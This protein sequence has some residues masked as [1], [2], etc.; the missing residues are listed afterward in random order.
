MLEIGDF[1]RVDGRDFGIGKL[2]SFHDDTARVSWFHSPALPIV[3]EL[4]VPARSVQRVELDTQHRVYHH[5]LDTGTWRVGRIEDCGRIDGHHFGSDGDLYFVAFPNGDT[6]RVPIAQLETRWDRPLDAP[7]SIL[8]TRT[9]ITPFWHEGRAR[10]M[11]SVMTQRAACG[12]LTGLFSASVDLLEHQVRVVRTVLNDPIPR[13]L[14]ADEVGLGKTIEAIAILRQLVLERP[15]DHATLIVA[16]PH[17]HE[18]WA[19]EL[20]WRFRLGPLLGESIRIIDLSEI[21][22]EEP[23]RLL[24]VDEAHH[25]AGYAH[26]ASEEKRD[27]YRKLSRLAHKSPRLLLLSATPVLHNEDGFLAMLHLLDPVAYPL[28]DR[29]SFR[30]RVLQRQQIADWLSDLQDDASPLFMEDALDGLAEHFSGDARLME[31]V[32]F[33]R[34]FVDE[35]EDDEARQEML[36][37]LRAH[38]GEVYRLHRRMLRTRRVSLADPLWGRAGTQ[39]LTCE[40][41]ARVEAE[42]LLLDWRGDLM[43]AVHNDDRLRHTALPLWRHFM[44][45]ALS[46]PLA[47]R[48]LASARLEHRGPTRGWSACSLELLDA[49]PFFEGE[50]ERL[51]ELVEIL[52]DYRSPRDDKL[53]EHLRAHPGERF[54]VFVDRPASAERL[55]AFLSEALGDEVRLH[56]DHED[57]VAF[58]QQ[59]TVRVLLCDFLAEEGL[60]LNQ[61]P[62]SIVHFD[63]PL[64]PNR[65]EQ[66]IGRLDRI[67][68]KRPVTSVVFDDGAP[69]AAAWLALLRDP[70]GVFDESIASLQYVLEEHINTFV[71]RTFAEGLEAFD[72]LDVALRDDKTGLAAELARVR[73]QEALERRSV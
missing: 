21:A 14:L 4:D 62:A 47:L 29:D 50:S 17:L 41:S 66:R 22:S 43:L 65:V 19:D 52:E 24:I 59:K 55:Q 27:V 35:G 42:R 61:S 64:D 39:V 13:Y 20:S 28:E 18:Q 54:V 53:L 32:R 69:L 63:L 37:S 40:D 3:R 70:I 7:E 5:E 26:Q 60:N 58:T 2:V 56:R 48:D 49:P 31:L 8:A 6:R 71:G 57:V 45:A 38:I 15:Y 16:P 9:T 68:S 25:P 23:P 73:H 67:G 46:H 10:L 33:T 44:G 1:V 30:Q 36:T 34:P 12:G 72:A 51:R 11:R